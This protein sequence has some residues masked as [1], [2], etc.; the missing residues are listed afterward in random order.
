MMKTETEQM[1]ARFL[2]DNPGMS[3]HVKRDPVLGL[4]LSEEGVAA[5]AAWAVKKGL[6]TQAKA[7]VGMQAID[8]AKEE[9]KADRPWFRSN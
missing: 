7:D 3:G 6:T 8:R 4:M 2:A 1:I 9:M 5:L